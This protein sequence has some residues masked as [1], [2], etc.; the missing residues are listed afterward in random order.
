MKTKTPIATL[1]AGVVAACKRVER[2]ANTPAD[3][4]HVAKRN[5]RAA[6]MIALRK[7]RHGI[8]ETLPSQRRS[9][10]RATEKPPEM[11]TD[12]FGN[13]V[14]SGRFKGWRVVPTLSRLAQC[15]LAQ[16]RIYKVLLRHQNVRKP[17]V[18]P[19]TAGVPDEKLAVAARHGWR[20]AAVE[21][22]KAT[23]E[24]TP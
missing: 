12:Q 20:R 13:Y 23:L 6:A 2:I 5:A 17:V 16:I 3:T 8:V 7:L 10:R 18:P 19:W 22:V 1:L 11:A 9:S 24:V 21:R 15:A 14:V 4:G